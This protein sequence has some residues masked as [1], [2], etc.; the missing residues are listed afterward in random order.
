MPFSVKYWMIEDSCTISSDMMSRMVCASY[1]NPAKIAKSESVSLCSSVWDAFGFSVKIFLLFSS[2]FG[3]SNNLETLLRF[4]LQHLSLTCFLNCLVAN[5]TPLRCICQLLL[6][7]VQCR[8]ILRNYWVG[9][10]F[11]RI[12]C[13]MLRQAAIGCEFFCRFLKNITYIKY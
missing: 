2:R 3:Y 1:T 5:Y 8:S 11:F 7:A 13:K 12:R 6:G 9:H 4:T 10:L